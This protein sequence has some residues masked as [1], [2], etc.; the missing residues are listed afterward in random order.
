MKSTSNF[1]G[2]LEGFFTQ[3]LMQQRQASPHT[4]A[5]YRDTFRLLFRFTE[6]RLHK[7][8]SRL[9]LEEIDAP[10]VTAFLSD[11][12]KNRSIAPRSRNLRLTAIRSFFRYAAY[13]APTHSAQIQRMLAIPGK[14]YDRV[15]IHFLSHDEVDALLSAPER[16]T[17]SG[18]RDHALLM[19]AIQTG[20]RL[21]ELIGLKR[22]DAMIGTGAYVRCTGKGRKE[23]CT[24]LT[25]QTRGVLKN[26]LN[27]PK[28]VNTEMPSVVTSKPAICGHFKTGHG[29]FP[30]LRCCTLPSAFRASLIC[31][32]SRWRPISSSKLEK[33]LVY[34]AVVAFSRGL[35]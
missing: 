22:Q 19:V 5:S 23:R 17:W 16:E 1:P 35:P 27:E 2:L 32:I 12:E 13:E 28:K 7:P 29:R 10:L 25:K 30:E 15:E 6:K 3:R 34:M 33:N 24:P 31:E 9:T 8:P 18:R 4:I 21:S 11:L 20:L 14:R 26:W